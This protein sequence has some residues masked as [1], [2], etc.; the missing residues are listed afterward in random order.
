M[1]RA[2]DSVQNCIVVSFAQKPSQL[3]P[4]GPHIGWYFTCVY[5][6]SSSHSE[7]LHIGSKL[8]VVLQYYFLVTFLKLLKILPEIPLKGFLYLKTTYDWDGNSI[9]SIPFMLK[10]LTIMTGI[11]LQA[12]CYV[13]TTCYH[14]RNPIKSFP[15][16]LKPLT[17]MTGIPLQAFPLC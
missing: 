2:R 4:Y 15:F 1:G 9:T 7:F 14:D 16:M 8:F 11:P 5:C 10:P 3:S 17:I 12:S 13:K 6:K